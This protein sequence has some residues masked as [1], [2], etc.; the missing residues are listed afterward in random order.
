MCGICGTYGKDDLDLIRKMSDSMLHR[1]PDDSGTYSDKGV[2]FGHRRLSIIDL[3]TG[4]QPVHNEDGS[5]WVM[6]NGEI[7]NY[8]ELRQELKGHEFYTSSDTEVIV[9][10]YEDDPERF[11]DKLNG[12]FALAIWD[13]GRKRLTLARDPL[14]KKPLYYCQEGGVLYFGS[15]IKAI[16][17]AGVSKQVDE[18]MI[19]G[20]LGYQFCLG[21]RTLFR[22][23]KK[24]MAGNILRAS[25]GNF[26][27]SRYWDIVSKPTTTTDTAAAEHLRGL[28]ERSSKYR[29]IA[30]VPIGAFLSGGI[31]SS[32]V[33]ALTK[34]HVDY[35]YHTISVGF[36]THSELEY[37]KIVSSHVGTTHHELIITPEMVAKNLEKI[38]WHYDEPVGDQAIV[39]NYFL[40]QE[41]RK[42]VKV[43]VAGEA[44]DELFAGYPNYAQNL[45]FEETRHKMYGGI[46][47]SLMG[48]YPQRGNIFRNLYEKEMSTFESDNIDDMMLRS[49]RE[50]SD[51]EIKW[52]R[53]KQP[54]NSESLAIMPHD[55]RYRLDRMLYIDCKNRL[56]EK[57]LMKA[58]KATMA[59]S[60]EE[61]LPLMDKAIAEFAFTL[62]PALKLN[63][64]GEKF[65]LR[66][67]VKDLLPPEIVKRKK[68][69]FATPV[70]DWML[71]EVG[72]IALAELDSSEFLKAHFETK[73][74]ERMGKGLR[75]KDGK[76]SRKIWTVYALGLWHRTF[77]GEEH[78]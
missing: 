74:L 67:A 52:L 21:E 42:Y 57:Y 40:S 44:G 7:Y 23:I 48:I 35:E 32:A 62:P 22:G 25:E 59:N 41:A 66:L 29:M 2:A 26:E 14:G 63:P 73:R 28:L 11:V 15:E 54:S 4:H 39:N 20:Y 46:A 6:L 10:L 33:V 13:S 19:D 72:E 47:K 55:I 45:Q 5:V 75:L 16:L 36:P 37:A 61:R 76:A 68:A 34:P 60:I 31:D 65:V 71:H 50:L 78:K 8:R 64:E 17:A 53:W 3:N 38:A 58:D 69:G 51:R 12:M 70:D 27:I 56:P 1:G 30:D 49:I 77:F 18:E 9:H 43:V 24:L